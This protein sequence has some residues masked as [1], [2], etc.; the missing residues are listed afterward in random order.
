ML[1]ENDIKR[2]FIPFLKEFYKFR[3]EYRADTVK[4]ELDNVS[5]GGLIAD[6]MLSFRKAD[7]TIFVCTYEATSVGKAEEVKFTLNTLY[8]TW[9]CLA[10]GAVA[11]TIAYAVAFAFRFPWLVSLQWTGNLGFALGMGLIGFLFWYFTMQGWKKYRY[12]YA[13]EQFKQYF[14]HEQW[15]ALGEDVFPSKTDPY[16]TELRSQCIYNGFGLALV[17]YK[18]EVRVLNAPSRLGIYGKDRAMAHWVTKRSWYQAMSQNVTTLS[19]YRSALPGD[20]TQAWNK[21]WRPFRYLF[22]DQVS[23]SLS[24]AVSQPLSRRNTA[25]DRYMRGQ[26]VQKWVFFLALAAIIPMAYEVLTVRD[27]DVREVIERPETNPEDQYGYLYEGESS[28]RRDPR[29]IPKQYPDPVSPPPEEIPTINLSGRDDQEE[30]PTI[31]LSG[32]EEPEPVSTGVA[33]PE[34]SSDP[35]VA[36][37]RLKGWIIQDNSFSSLAFAR[38]RA[39]ALR[40]KGIEC[41]IIP[42]NCLGEGAG[43]ILQLGGTV[44]GEQDAINKAENYTRAMERYGLLQGTL[45]VR[46][47][48]S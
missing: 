46:R 25:F 11:A 39:N 29:G 47:I 35:C 1:S 27:D 21:V 41:T 20:W 2:A 42:K 8:F 13:V 15:I 30:I 37:R 14:A 22:L 45:L 28:A 26:S 18:S 48:N 34:S 32:D 33:V 36:I 23:K 24:K 6:G 5:A 12:I 3:Y 19:N 16:L 38:E 44:A 31:N 43:Y 4:T 9:D 7:G 10:F 40:R 17:S